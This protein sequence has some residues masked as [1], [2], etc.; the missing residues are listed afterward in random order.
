MFL[1]GFGEN[2]ENILEVLADNL[3]PSVSDDEDDIGEIEVSDSESVTSNDDSLSE[4]F[5]SLQNAYLNTNMAANSVNG[6]EN[7]LTESDD[8]RD[9]GEYDV[10][11]ECGDKECSHCKCAH[12]T[13]ANIGT[14]GSE[15]D[16]DTRRYFDTF[17]PSDVTLVA[18]NS[19]IPCH[20]SVIRKCSEYFEAMFESLMLESTQNRIELKE[21]PFS[22]LVSPNKMIQQKDIC[23][24]RFF[25][26]TDGYYRL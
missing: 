1:A 20:K 19:E 15:M 3:I 22:G 14:I 9:D 12:E 26:L 24:F 4:A 8:R 17:G 11:M 25:R 6:V 16:A 18:G 13:V 2:N 5:I 21:V 23:F 10:N 7:N